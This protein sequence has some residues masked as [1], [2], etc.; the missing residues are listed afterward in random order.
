VQRLQGGTTVS[1]GLATHAP[2]L[3]PP[4]A[5]HVGVYK[6]PAIVPDPTS[7]PTTYPLRPTMTLP[8]SDPPLWTDSLIEALPG[9][10]PWYDQR[11]PVQLSELPPLYEPFA[12]TP[13]P[14]PPG[15]YGAFELSNASN[16]CEPCPVKP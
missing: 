4:G 10:I 13:A 3:Y 9:L 8:P 15:V 16:V 12:P 6:L 1:P 14:S 11:S 7:G 2:A 5:G